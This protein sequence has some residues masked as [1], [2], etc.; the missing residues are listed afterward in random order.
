MGWWGGGVVK[1]GGFLASLSR[2]LA[3]S[4]SPLGRN[5]Q[6]SLLQPVGLVVVEGG[7]GPQAVYDVG[8]DVENGA[9]LGFGGVAG[10]AEPDGT[11]QDGVG[12]AHGGEDMG[13]VEAAGGAGGTRGGADAVLVE[14][15]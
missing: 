13:G 11:V 10:Q 4:P 14:H 8:H 3:T 2:H 9:D 12:Q 5:S 15:E 7:H 1:G 6:I